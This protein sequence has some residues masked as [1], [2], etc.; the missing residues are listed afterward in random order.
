MKKEIFIGVIVTLISTAVCTVLSWLLSLIAGTAEAADW[1]MNSLWLTIPLIIIIWGAVCYKTIHLKHQKEHPEFL[2]LTEM[3]VGNGQK[4][5]WRWKKEDNGEWEIDEFKPLC[6][7]C[8]AVLNFRLY[9]GYECVNGHLYHDFGYSEA[10]AQVV[11][12]IRNRYSDFA[13]LIS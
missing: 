11:H 5:V 2:K 7:S 4:W 6:P 8:S 9:H 13:H 10:Y 1:L 3:T 12:E